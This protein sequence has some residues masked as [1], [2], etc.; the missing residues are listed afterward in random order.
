MI[1]ISFMPVV[2]LRCCSCT[3]MFLVTTTGRATVLL[4][5]AGL[6]DLSLGGMTGEPCSGIWTRLVCCCC[7]CFFLRTD[8]FA[9][10]A[11]SSGFKLE[12]EDMS[13]PGGCLDAS[14][15]SLS[16]NLIKLF[17]CDLE[18]RSCSEGIGVFILGS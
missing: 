11:G 6:M 17:L 5:M 2:R 7:C 9:S 14:D 10:L 15:F 18:E 4:G 8:G 1:C 12:F 13:G 3:S 16:G